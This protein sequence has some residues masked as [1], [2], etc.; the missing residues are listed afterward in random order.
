MTRGFLLLLFVV[1]I[2][3][4]VKSTAVASCAVAEIDG[5]DSTAV[6]EA[7]TDDP[8]ASGAS[9]QSPSL[10][11]SYLHQ[12]KFAEGET[13]LL[14]ALDTSPEDDS[15]RF[16]LG[17]IQF[18]RA[19]EN[20]G[21]SLYEY[22][23]MSQN[24]SM[25]FL[26]LPVPKNDDPST[27]SYRAL[28]RVLDAFATDLNRAE[29]TLASI[30]DDNVK[31]SL[32][33]SEIQFDFTRVGK[34][35]TTLIELLKAMNRGQ[36]FDFQKQNPEFRISFDRGDVAWLRAYCHLLSAIVNVYRAIDEEPGFERRVESFFP[37]IEKSR[38]VEDANWLDG[39]SI[40][41]PPRLR[42]ARLQLIS[43]CELNRET[44]RHIR[45]ETDNDFEWLSNPKQTD[46][47]G[48]PITNQQVDAWLG[49]LTELESLLKGESLIPSS[50]LI[51]ID[52]ENRH[53]GKGLN[54]KRFLDDPPLDLMNAKRM[55]ERGIDEKYLEDE[56][57]RKVID[58]AK[59][60]LAIQLFDGPFG[61]GRAARMN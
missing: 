1:A 54:L 40:A 5:T 59:L 6:V 45:A 30:K 44:W 15:A 41:D 18:L 49:A 26:R 20:F 36:Q 60:F 11:E 23:A 25:M 31:M 52:G 47:L 32:R 42:R 12:G 2:P 53:A 16:G 38:A 4:L 58:I 19:V 61:F 39:L 46:Q 10:A 14:L 33:L 56:K 34:E 37:K 9:T 22:G 3:L 51:F 8:V 29:V 35:R 55:R 17:V 50:L 24:S 28:G 7:T 13:A 43:V 27:I 57:G 48:L 21:Q